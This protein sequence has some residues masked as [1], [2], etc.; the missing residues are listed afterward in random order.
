MLTFSQAYTIYSFRR[1]ITYIVIAFVFTILTALIAILLVT[2]TGISAISDVLVQADPQSHTVT[3][4][5][6]NGSVFKKINASTVWP[7]T[8]VITLEFGQSNFPYQVLHTGID[9][10]NAQGKIGDP[11]TPFMQGKV[12]YAG[13][14]S[15]GYGKHI[16]IDHGD[17]MTSI[18]AHLS[19]INVSVGQDVKPGDIIGLMGS[20]GWS[21]GPHLHFQTNVF[22][23]PV[24]PR[25]FI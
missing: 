15:W 3:L 19:Q 25:V 10:A 11:I 22:G 7:I 8:G 14:I 17:N 1:E 21:T 16:I 12:I 24:N 4:F 9:I 13:E 6:P 20:T 18:Y 23:M 5:Y 2:Q